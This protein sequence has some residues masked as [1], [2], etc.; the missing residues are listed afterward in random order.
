[1]GMPEAHSSRVFHRLIVGLTRCHRNSLHEEDR[2]TEVNVSKVVACL[3]I[4]MALS[5]PRAA[6]DQVFVSSVGCVSTNTG[7]CAFRVINWLS[8]FESTYPGSLDLQDVTLSF[9]YEGGALSWHWDSILPA[10]VAGQFVETEALDPSIVGSLIS[11]RLDATLPRTEFFYPNSNVMFTADSASVSAVGTT[12]Y[13]DVYAE[14]QN[15]AV[16][17][18]PATLTLFSLGLIGALAGRLRK[19][20]H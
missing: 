12:P 7:D 19:R 14:G 5:A 20:R 3:A 2:M 17:P 6:A 9:Q 13:L 15:S 4:S 1:M 8:K 11:L 18:E 16:V 10:Y